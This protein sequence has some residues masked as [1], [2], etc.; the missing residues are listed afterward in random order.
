MSVPSRMNENDYRSI[1]TEAFAGCFEMIKDRIT[2]AYNVKV[3]EAEAPRPNTS[4]FDGVSILIEESLKAD[5]KLFV[6]LHVFGHT[7]QWAVSSARREIGLRQFRPGEIDDSILREIHRYEMEAGRYGLQLL[8]DA[9][10]RR[11]DQWLSD[12]TAADWR[13]LREIY[14]LGRRPDPVNGF[15]KRFLR[16]G[17]PLLQPLRIPEFRPRRWGT[18]AAF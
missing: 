14:L 10:V 4:F 2:T 5:M 9:G 13:Y 15:K 8:R 17:S 1:P 11:L 12:W 6:L 16:F 7:V 3:A 18:R